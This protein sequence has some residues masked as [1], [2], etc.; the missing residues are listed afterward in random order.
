MENQNQQKQVQTPP[1]GN[2]GQTGPVLELR[3]VYKGFGALQ[4]LRGVDLAVQSGESLVILGGSGSG[5][6]VTLKILIGLLRP[7]RGEVYFHGRRIDTCPANW[8]RSTRV[9]RVP[10][11]RCSIRWR[12]GER[13]LP[14]RA[15]IR[16]KEDQADR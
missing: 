13:G 15:A 2:A 11:G 12:G 14:L 8:S 3:G 6:S 1:A 5:K 7:E 9:G 16:E 10:D 4:V